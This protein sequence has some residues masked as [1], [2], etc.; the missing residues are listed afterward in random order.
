MLT[1]QGYYPLLFIICCCDGKV[2]DVNQPWVSS[3]AGAVPDVNQPWVLSTAVAVP[4]LNQPWFL[5]PLL[6][7]YQT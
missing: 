7:L 1:C 2:P 6:W 5:H 4:D 3:T